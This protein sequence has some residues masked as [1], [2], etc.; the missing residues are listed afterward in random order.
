MRAL[1]PKSASIVSSLSLYSFQLVSLGYSMYVARLFTPEQLGVLSL[2]LALVG[3]CEA[4]K[5]GGIG[6][7]LIRQKDLSKETVELCLGVTTLFSFFSGAV[8]ALSSS[9]IE[10]FFEFEELKLFIL[11]ASTNF[12][13]SPLI[14]V[15]S[16][17]LTRHFL[18]L[19]KIIIDW[20]QTIIMMV[21]TICIYKFTNSIYALIGGIVAG[22]VAQLLASLALRAPGMRYI[23]SFSGLGSIVSY[24]GKIIGSTL[25]ERIATSAP[26]VLVGKMSTPAD[27][28][29]QSKGM[30]TINLIAH[31]LIAGFRPVAMPYFSSKNKQDVNSY[32]YAT[33]LVHAVSLPII[34]SL[35]TFGG[36]LV[37][38]L[39]GDQWEISGLLAAP[40]AVWGTFINI[41]PFYRQ[42]LIVKQGE[43]SLMYRSLMQFIT[44]V[45]G[46]S[47]GFYLNGLYGAAIGMA[48]SAVAT[49]IYTHCLVSKSLDVSWLA[50]LKSFNKSF[51]LT[52]ACLL[53]SA[54]V[55]NVLS[56]LGL[57]LLALLCCAFIAMAVVWLFLVF[58]L[59]MEIKNIIV[60]AVAR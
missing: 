28:A 14:S 20:A 56:N 46:V 6:D 9:Y 29:F 4:L 13:L 35:A 7:Y 59:N 38:F 11:L 57:S 1:S 31:M 36:S 48:C 44:T 25:V 41:H 52:F 33:N 60:K 16:A 8:L 26:E 32:V 12:F 21:I 3:I 55:H 54:G 42:I 39:F 22:S 15:N 49:F 18:F 40:L 53:A 50:L 47:I 43:N 10:S 58:L 2:T 23:P 17:L 34:L 37:L 5:S 45:L 51:I 27:V 19:H 30:S 24:S